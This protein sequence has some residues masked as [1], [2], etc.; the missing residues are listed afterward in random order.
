MAALKQY[1]LAEVAKHNTQQDLWFVIDDKVY[2]VTKF[3]TEHPGGEEVLFE[4]AGKDATNEFNDVGHSTDAKKQMKQ[5]LIGEIIEAERKKK[6]AMP[7]CQRMAIIAGSALVIGLGLVL[8]YKA[9]K[10]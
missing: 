1:S 5:Y 7:E 6:P 10:K 8:I 4:S 3:Q 2:D 9:L